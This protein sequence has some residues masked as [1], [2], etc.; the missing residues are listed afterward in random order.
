M[1]MSTVEAQDT[2]ECK[3][4]FNQMLA[5]TPSG[6]WR[7]CSY[8]DLQG[9]ISTLTECSLGHLVASGRKHTQ[10]YVSLHHFFLNLVLIFRNA[11]AYI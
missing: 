3:V 5:G 8:S 7:K 6:R 9:K 2:A 10:V 4:H 11:E 1:L